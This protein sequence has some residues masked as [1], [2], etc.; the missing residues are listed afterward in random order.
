MNVARSPDNQRRC[1]GSVAREKR[2]RRLVEAGVRLVEDQCPTRGV[3]QDLLGVTYINPHEKTIKQFRS[4]VLVGRNAPP[5]PR[6]RERGGK[7]ASLAK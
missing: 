6:A 5:L 2:E 3:T 1:L 4:E 7:T